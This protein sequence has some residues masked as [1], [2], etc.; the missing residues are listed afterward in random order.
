[1]VEHVGCHEDGKVERRELVRVRH[2]RKGDARDRE[3][4]R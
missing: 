1:V 4:G 2:F 3:R